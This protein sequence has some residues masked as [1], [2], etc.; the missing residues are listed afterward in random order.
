MSKPIFSDSKMVIIYYCNTECIVCYFRVLILDVGGIDDNG[1]YKVQLLDM[2]MSVGEQLIQKN[3]GV[4]EATPVAVS[5]K[6]KQVF[7]PDTNDA[8][9]ARLY[10]AKSSETLGHY[11][12]ANI[13]AYITVIINSHFHVLTFKR[14]LIL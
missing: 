8:V 10:T 3:I 11:G 5:T 12:Y 6:V 13:L 7:T 2:G 9:I 14:W 4:L 1:V